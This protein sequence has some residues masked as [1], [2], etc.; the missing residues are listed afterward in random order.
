M[1]RPKKAAEEKSKDA[2][3]LSIDVESF[4]RTRDQ[5]VS[6]LA[7]L[8]DA[9]QNLS[10]AYI[11]H[12][13]AILSDHGEGLGIDF[14]L[15]QQLSENPILAAHAAAGSPKAAGDKEE[16]QKRKKRQH[17][18][19]APKRPLTPFF[20]YMQTARP[21]IAQDLGD[22]PKGQVS[23]EG[24]ARWKALDDENRTLWTN[25]YKENLRL[26]NARMRSYK[27]DHN[28]NA[29][30]MSDADALAYA[31]E[32]NIGTE[33]ATADAQLVGEA[34]DAGHPVDEDE[35]AEGEPDKEPTPPPVVK[36]TPKAKS[37]RKSKGAKE[38]APV[39][40][41]EPIVPS[42]SSIVPP[43]APEPENTPSKVE[44]PKAEKRKRSSKK[45]EAK[46]EEPAAVEAP[47]SSSKSRKKKAKTEA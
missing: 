40:A 27:V 38:K 23:E 25:A 41:P 22:V 44:K 29:K 5:F 19:N 26:Y 20:L 43:K 6:G 39:P 47:K 11:K 2:A 34:H 33:T 10:T 15:A 46:E 7:T 21:I 24:T 4:V 9:I 1:A 17:D 3:T 32:H 12:T 42:S 28:P 30:D 45:E 37:S 18:P 14:A 35:D 13:N 8:Q 31:E 16:V 36:S